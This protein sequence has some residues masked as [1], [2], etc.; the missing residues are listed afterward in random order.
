MILGADPYQYPGPLFLAIYNWVLQNKDLAIRLWQILA[1]ICLLNFVVPV[2]FF[3]K[4]LAEKKWLAPT[5]VGLGT[6]LMVALRLPN[7]LSPASLWDE[8]EW[9][10]DAARLLTY[11]RPHQDVDFATSGFIGPY[12]LTLLKYTNLGI[13]SG[14]VRFFASLVLLLP[15]ILLSYASFKQIL[16]PQRAFALT[17]LPTLFWALT[18]KDPDFYNYNSE[19]LCF[20][21]LVLGYYLW[22]RI[23]NKSYTY[24]LLFLGGLV[25]GLTPYCKLQ[26]GPI[27]LFLGIACAV[28]LKSNEKRFFT[29]ERW[30]LFLGALAPTVFFLGYLSING[31]LETY[32]REGILL[33]L[34]YSS[35]PIDGSDGSWWGK[36][37][38]MPNYYNKEGASWLYLPFLT[39]A[40]AYF[41]IAKKVFY[42]FKEETLFELLLWLAI[43]ISLYCVHK[44]GNNFGHYM[45]LAL[46]PLYMWGAFQIG[47][48]FE[49]PNHFLWAFG[50]FVVLVIPVIEKKNAI[51]TSIREENIQVPY[52]VM[53]Q[54]AQK[55]KDYGAKPNETLIVFGYEPSVYMFTGMVPGIRFA[56]AY[57]YTF[58]SPYKKEMV[59]EFY[60]EMDTHKPKWLLLDTLYSMFDAK[61]DLQSVGGL[62]TYINSR[63]QEM[64]RR[65]EFIFY[66]RRE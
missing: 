53:S 52:V 31:I 62:E 9:I 1:Y 37:K 7:V 63:Y 64:G 22:F 18:N 28:T 34:S 12:L 40:T 41:I 44:T 19:Q 21:I 38:G 60:K 35:N 14:S 50:V 4:F 56:T 26:V 65:D 46:V 48:K 58:Y 57:H 59:L 45:L 3:P 6:L 24:P 30:I 10:A 13:N 51:L 43:P 36:I 27:V 15:G 42:P 20:P 2:L 55:L 47:T 8:S 25:L 16:S 17:L 32:I 11:H 61:Y 29:K 49:N 5:L 39:A 54:N 66:K 33:N 23:K